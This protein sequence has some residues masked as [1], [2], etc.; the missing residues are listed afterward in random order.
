VATGLLIPV[1]W[2]IRRRL[3]GMTLRGQ[4]AMLAPGVHV[5][6]CVAATYLLVAIV[7]AGHELLVLALGVPAAV[8]VG[9][10]VLRL[11]HPAQLAE[12]IQMGNRLVGRVRS[13]VASEL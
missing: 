4:V 2:I 12:L 8:A 7:I 3:L 9:T 11:F 6:S 13:G 5:A 1:E 10:L